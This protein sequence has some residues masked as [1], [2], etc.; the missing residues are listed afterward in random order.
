MG[1][2][3]CEIICD[4]ANKLIHALLLSPLYHY[5]SVIRKFAILLIALALV[6]I[7]A[8]AKKKK[9]DY[10]LVNVPE[11]GGVNFERITGIYQR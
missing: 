10:S 2:G 5:H 8:D 1:G 11:E 6:A 7:L 3:K 9:F 4:F